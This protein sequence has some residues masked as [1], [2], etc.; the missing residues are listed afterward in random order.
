[1]NYII[2]DFEENY[3]RSVLVC[4]HDRIIYGS[5]IYQILY[6]P[7]ST[8]T[9]VCDIKNKDVDA[10]FI[11]YSGVDSTQLLFDAVKG[12]EFEIYIGAPGVPVNP[13][14]P[15]LIDKELLPSFY[16]FTKRVLKYYHAAYDKYGSLFAGVYQSFEV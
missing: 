16:E 7:H 8:Q 11:N 6:L 1:M 3:N 4:E 2:Y 9:D 14:L 10:V 5:R 13:A 12:Q 15:S